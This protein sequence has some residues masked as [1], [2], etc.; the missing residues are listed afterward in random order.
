MTSL[1]IHTARLLGPLSLLLSA[2]S[3]GLAQEGETCGWA[4]DPAGHSEYTLDTRLFHDDLNPGPL[5]AGSEANGPD[6]VFWFS[7]NPDGV[8]RWEADFD[9]VI[10]VLAGECGTD[11]KEA[12]AGRS[13]TLHFFGG[14]PPGD[15]TYFSPYVIV[16]GL[17]GDAG[18]IT[19]W[20]EVRWH[21][22]SA[23]ETW[24]QIKRLFREV[25]REPAPR[26]PRLISSRESDP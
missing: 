7:G 18:L 9:A 26:A 19:L 3:A 23:E 15:V 1:R 12:Q 21:D 24:G 2:G 6:A 13:G 5:W 17:N 22:P 20:F 25:F 14:Y 11:C 16:D 8:V 10:Y 4:I